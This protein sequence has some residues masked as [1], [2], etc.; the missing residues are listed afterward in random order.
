MVD[1]LVTADS[2]HQWF[3]IM[4]MEIMEL[5]LDE[6]LKWSSVQEILYETFKKIF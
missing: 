4:D 5:V 6:E 3:E 2:N 1:V